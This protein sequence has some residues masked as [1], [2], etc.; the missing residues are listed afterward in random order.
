MIEAIAG[1]LAGFIL[2]AW[3][4]SR[5]ERKRLYQNLQLVLPG[6]LARLGGKISLNIRDQDGQL[7]ATLSEPENGKKP[8]G[9][10]LKH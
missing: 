5:A 2:G 4:G 9:N 1:L 3:L 7:V 6:V 10:M 8:P